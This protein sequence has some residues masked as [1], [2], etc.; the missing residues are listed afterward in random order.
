LK[1]AGL[2][3]VRLKWFTID[4]RLILRRAGALSDLDRRALIRV[5][6]GALRA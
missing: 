6:T 2:S 1:T 3:A 4:N 5:V